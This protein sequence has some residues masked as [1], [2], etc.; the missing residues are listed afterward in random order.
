VLGTILP[1]AFVTVV[2]AALIA[3]VVLGYLK[4]KRPK[5]I[6]KATPPPMHVGTHP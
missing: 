1:L 2:C 6:L 3:V 5:L 4:Y